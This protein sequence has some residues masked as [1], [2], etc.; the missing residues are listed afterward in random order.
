MARQRFDKV[1]YSFNPHTL[2]YEKV[3]R[4]WR[5]YLKR[6]FGILGLG[7]ASGALFFFLYI[8]FIQSP[9]ERQLVEENNMIRTQ[10]KV[11][12]RQLDDAIKIMEIIEERD[13][14]FYRVMLEADSIPISMR[15]GTSSLTARYDKWKNL[16]VGDIVKETT[17][18]MDVLNRML[19]IQSSS[20]DELVDLALK[21]EDRL[22]H[23]PAIMPVMN[24]DLKRTASGYG[25][26]IDPIY[27]TK[28][29]HK[30]MDFS[31]EVGTEIYATGAGTVTFAGW[32]QGYGNCVMIDHGYDYETLYAHCSKIKKG[33]RRGSKVQ[34][35]DVI[36]YVGNT[37]KSTGPHLHYEVHVDGQPQ[38]PSH[39]YYLDL[40]P[41][42]YD[43]MIRIASDSGKMFD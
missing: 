14:N 12:N 33:L 20:F 28:R 25:Y 1:H 30:G 31:A 24:K 43:E 4:D 19:Y 36:A 2:K 23:I 15:K 11:L 35:G 27:Q 34:R 18:K 40:S 41:D 21:N 8:T 42:Q 13:D 9:A 26:R 3:V 29:F 37:G 39:Y 7:V 17:Q 38:N 10:F 6:V 22:K 16:R 5:Y 32:K